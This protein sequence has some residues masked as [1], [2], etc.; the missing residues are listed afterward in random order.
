VADAF[1][2]VAQAEAEARAEEEYTDAV[3]DYES[4]L[5]D[6]DI[7]LETKP[8]D[9]DENDNIIVDDKQMVKD[10]LSTRRKMSGGVRENMTSGMGKAKFDKYL[11]QSNLRRNADY[12]A[13]ATERRIKALGAQAKHKV[14][15]LILGGNHDAAYERGK[16]ALQNQAI[17]QAEFDSMRITINRD[18]TTSNIN[19]AL[20]GDTSHGELNTLVDVL[21]DG[22]WPGGQEIGL[23]GDERYSYTVRINRKLSDMDESASI[24]VE[25]TRE[26]AYLDLLVPTV[27]GEM[28]VDE[29]R[30]HRGELDGSRFD[31]LVGFAITASRRPRESDTSILETY[32]RRVIELRIGKGYDPTYAGFKDTVDDVIEAMSL[33]AGMA[34]ADIN[35]LITDLDSY[36]KAINDD[37]SLEDILNV[38][39]AKITGRKV[40][41]FM[42]RFEGQDKSNITEAQ[43]LERDFK[44]AMLQA[45]PKNVVF[46]GEEWMRENV[47][48]YHLKVQTDTL[49]RYKIPEAPVLPSGKIDSDKLGALM[50]QFQIEQSKNNQTG[51]GLNEQQARQQAEIDFQAYL[52]MIEAG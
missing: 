1:S 10:E 40:D 45:G 27:N 41:Q 22:K 29:I 39:L 31:K 20:M 2:Q 34:T 38:E 33:D 43:R 13:R 15:T 46:N 50:L 6:Y 21:D 9:L 14:N 44:R 8:F 16:V 35:R 24:A 4:Q 42:V 12:T 32:E 19:N 23:T 52:R 17:S 30:T 47:G 36:V 3:F 48:A 18:R 28:S 25:A 26:Q 5:Q 51:Q 7:E 11:V 37:D 49:K